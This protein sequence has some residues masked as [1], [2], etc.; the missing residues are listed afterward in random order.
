MTHASENF[1]HLYNFAIK[2]NKKDKA[3]VCEQTKPEI[4][5]LRKNSMPSPFRNRPIEEVSRCLKI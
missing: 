1:D 3:F 4:N 2:L 5:E